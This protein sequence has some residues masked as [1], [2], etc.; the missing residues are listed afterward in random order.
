[1]M[2]TCEKSHVGMGHYV[3][4]VCGEQHGEVVLLDK[5]LRDTLCR[6]NMMGYQ[7]CPKHEELSAEYLALVE[8]TSDPNEGPAEFTGR[9]AH[10]RWEVAEQMFNPTPK[11]EQPFVFVSGDLMDQL[12]AFAAS[13]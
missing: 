6:D 3:C 12:Q 11:R 2:T 4:P 9:T 7:L 5:R 8:T 10:L 1:M 13:T